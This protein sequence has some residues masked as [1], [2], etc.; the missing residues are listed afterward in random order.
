MG[1]SVKR[2]QSVGLERGE[3]L[4]G[5]RGAPPCASY[6]AG[7]LVF[8]LTGEAADPEESKGEVLWAQTV[9]TVKG[10]Q[11]KFPRLTGEKMEK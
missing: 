4:E 10:I 8:N 11:G 9:L 3:S 2:P 1:G 6:A 7:G 5:G